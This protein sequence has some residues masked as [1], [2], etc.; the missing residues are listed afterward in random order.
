MRSHALFV[1]ALMP[2]LTILLDCP[3]DLGLTRSRER[4][5]AAGVQIDEGRFEE[6]DHSFHARV[7]EGYLKLASMEPER[8]E[9]V[10]ADAAPDQIRRRIIRT[11]L[12]RLSGAGYAL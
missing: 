1:E 12:Q 2:D 6:L 7:R 10:N 9:V 8:F 4:N 5:H 11:V 3:V